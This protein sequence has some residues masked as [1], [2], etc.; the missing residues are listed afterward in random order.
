MPVF[1]LAANERH[2]CHRRRTNM[3]PGAAL[4]T[5]VAAETHR[6]AADR[7]VVPSGH[8]SLPGECERTS[9][10]HHSSSRARLETQNRKVDGCRRRESHVGLNTTSRVLGLL[11]EYGVFILR[12][13]PR[14]TENELMLCRMV[15]ELD[16]GVDSLQRSMT[17]AQD[18][19]C[20]VLSRLTIF[21]ENVSL[22]SSHNPSRESP[23]V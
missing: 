1:K 3:A 4:S 17:D 6:C 9:H 20:A 8:S 7:L 23:Q 16:H 15:G 22:L 13:E 11:D 14:A 10:L 5:G 21:I 12:C 18:R 2:R 19:A